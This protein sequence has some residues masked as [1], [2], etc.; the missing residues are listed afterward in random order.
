MTDTDEDIV[1]R[2]DGLYIGLLSDSELQILRRCIESGFATLVYEGFSG[3]LGL[4]KV[5]VK[6][7]ETRGNLND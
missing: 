3:I 2:M 4:G 5:K 7:S 6:L 1:R